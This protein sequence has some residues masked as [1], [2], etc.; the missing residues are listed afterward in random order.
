MLQSCPGPKLWSM[1]TH[2]AVLLSEYPS[3]EECRH[4]CVQETVNSDWMLCIYL[5]LSQLQPYLLL[6]HL[7]PYP[8]LTPY[9]CSLPLSIITVGVTELLVLLSLLTLMALCCSCWRRWSLLLQPYLYLLHPQPTTQPQ[10]LPLLLRYWLQLP[11]VSAGVL[12]ERDVTAA[13]PVVVITDKNSKQKQ[14]RT[15]VPLASGTDMWLWYGRW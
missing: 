12:D 15:A 7:Q 2:C 9:S 5:L 8:Q 6:L 14:S 4:V 1:T 3:V 13:F 11:P 10:S